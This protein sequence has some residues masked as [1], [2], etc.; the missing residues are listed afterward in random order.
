MGISSFSAKYIHVISIEDGTSVG[1]LREAIQG[2]RWRDSWTHSVYALR[3]GEKQLMNA[4][5]PGADMRLF[6]ITDGVPA[7]DN[8]P[9]ETVE[10]MVA[11]LEHMHVNSGIET[12]I[13]SF[14]GEDPPPDH[15]LEKAMEVVSEANVTHVEEGLTFETAKKMVADVGIQI[16]GERKHPV[17]ICCEIPN[18]INVRNR[19]IHC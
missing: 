1:A 4:T 12:A 9:A 15:E 17:K 16:P 6:F 8:D 14:L 19:L 10:N 5:R 2:M 11:T 13:V 3:E 18:E 7:H